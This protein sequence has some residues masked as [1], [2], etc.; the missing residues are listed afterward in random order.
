VSDVSF[1]FEAIRNLIGG[2]V[3]AV[4]LMF[5]LG[6]ALGLLR[7]P[8]YYTRLHANS[9]ADGAGAAVFVLGLAVLAPDWTIALRLMLLGALI[10]MLAPTF[11][12]LGAN[13]AHSAGLAPLSG[14]YTAPRPGAPPRSER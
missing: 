9:V 1:I 14:S 7:F 3:A 11:A 10:A 4:G 12:H 8:D 5:M 2:A 6:G 13:A